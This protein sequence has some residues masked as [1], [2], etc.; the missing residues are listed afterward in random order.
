[1]EIIQL[2]GR[3]LTE[4]IVLPLPYLSLVIIIPRKSHKFLNLLFIIFFFFPTAKIMFFL[5]S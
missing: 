4:T 2:N 5:T 3:N 1:M